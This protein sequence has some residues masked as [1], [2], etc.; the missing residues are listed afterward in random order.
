MLLAKMVPMNDLFAKVKQAAGTIPNNE[1]ETLQ[2][3]LQ[4]Y[5]DPEGRAPATSMGAPWAEGTLTDQDRLQFSSGVEKETVEGR[6]A[7]LSRSFGGVPS[8]ATADKGLLKELFSEFGSERTTSHSP[9]LQKK[10]SHA[11]PPTLA[12]AIRK[13]R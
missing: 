5:A 13:L 12:E 10:A 11:P 4:M 3:N 8:M 2:G 1:G 9:L 6:G 7:L